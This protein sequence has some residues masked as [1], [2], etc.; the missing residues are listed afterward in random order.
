MFKDVNPELR[1][2]LEKIWINLLY[3]PMREEESTLESM[4]RCEVNVPTAQHKKIVH[5][6]RPGGAGQ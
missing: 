3:T 5:I 4:P 1:K 2:N 6:E